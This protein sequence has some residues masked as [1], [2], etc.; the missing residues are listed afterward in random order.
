MNKKARQKE[1]ELEKALLTELAE[2]CTGI[3]E[4]VV[5]SHDGCFGILSV[6]THPVS[7]V[8]IALDLFEGARLDDL[9][10]VSNLLRQAAV[11]EQSM[12]YWPHLPHVIPGLE[13]ALAEAAQ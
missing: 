4:Y 12:L 13:E 5:S 8:E 7:H 3:T 1:R 6:E 9:R 10:K 11:D 2:R